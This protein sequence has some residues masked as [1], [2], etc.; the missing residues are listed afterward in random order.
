[1]KILQGLLT[2]HTPFPSSPHN[3]TMGFLYI[4]NVYIVAIEDH[5]CEFLISYFC[6]C[7]L[8]HPKTHAIVVVFSTQETCKISCIQYNGEC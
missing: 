2:S 3:I 7:Q 1:M 6:Q 4:S 5:K 8:D